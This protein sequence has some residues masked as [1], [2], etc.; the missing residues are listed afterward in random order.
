VPKA[1]SEIFMNKKVIAN[2]EFAE[3]QTDMSED[4]SELD[5]RVTYFSPQPTFHSNKTRKK[6][7]YYH[8]YFKRSIKNLHLADGNK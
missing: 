7:V 8:N 6:Y 3:E 2:L 4:Y 5:L 1:E